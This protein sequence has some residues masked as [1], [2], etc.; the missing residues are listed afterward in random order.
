MRVHAAITNQRS[1]AQHWELLYLNSTW[2]R[3]TKPWYSIRPPRADLASKNNHSSSQV[4][5][6]QDLDALELPAARH[7]L[8]PAG[9]REGLLPARRG[10]EGLRRRL[11][12]PDRRRQ[13]LRHQ[14][15]GHQQFLR[16]RGLTG[17]CVQQSRWVFPIKYNV[18]KILS[19]VFT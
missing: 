11:Q 10:L 8:V 15:H 16:V 13:G 7:R 14:I 9:L 17:F 4:R 18:G 1:S 3:L 6:V 5:R 19:M 12:R 2:L